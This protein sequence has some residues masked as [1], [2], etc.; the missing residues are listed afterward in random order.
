TLAEFCSTDRYDRAAHTYGRSYRDVVRGYRGDF[1]PA[2]AFVA[3]PR[4]EQDVV[5][6]LDWCSSTGV[7]AVPFGGGSSVVGGVECPGAV[8]I[9]MTRM[10]RVLDVDSVSR[11][12]RIQAGALG[13]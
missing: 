13:P 8:S 12:A 11:A 7:A 5:A 2:P 4:N 10:N 1:S 9:D 6:V 3:F